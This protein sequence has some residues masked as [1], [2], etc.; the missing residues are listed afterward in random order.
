MIERA[1]PRPVTPYYPMIT[2]AL[3]AE[4]S[5]A[6]V[7]IRPPAEALR[8]AQAFVDHLTRGAR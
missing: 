6:L 2:D 1:R 5:A 7:G 3:Q 8:R 4:M